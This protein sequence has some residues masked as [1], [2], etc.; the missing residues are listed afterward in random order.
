M[1][2]PEPESDND[3]D[4]RP[5]D[6]PADR[7]GFRKHVIVETIGE[8]ALILATTEENYSMV[9]L[10][11]EF[12]AN[13]NVAN[14]YGWIPLM[15]AA[16]WGRRRNVEILLKTG[17]KKDLKCTNKGHRRRAIDFARNLPKNVEDRSHTGYKE[18]TYNRNLDKRYIVY[19]LGG[20]DKVGN[21]KEIRPIGFAFEKSPTIKSLLSFFAHFDIPGQNKTI[22]VLWRGYD[23]PVKAAIS[24][25]ANVE[26]G[27][28]AQG[29]Y[30]IDGR[31]YT[32]AV[33]E[34][35][36]VVGHKL[37]SHNYNQGKAGQFYASHAEK[38]LVAY[39]V[40]RHLFLSA[41]PQ[42]DRLLKQSSQSSQ[43]SPSSPKL[44]P[45]LY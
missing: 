37:D 7:T 9:E 20:V 39:F 16:L 1:V 32:N 18:D 10:L 8:T 30:L 17:A 27:A 12:K 24:G 6:I 38:Q 28:V 26:S 5:N 15:A 45:P 35:C 25:W 22:G 4:S 43:S 14:I 3:E 29:I 13:P 40:D 41:N 36:K 23:F 33:F 42:H 11:L 19:L 31:D 34:L 44:N 2:E 21:H